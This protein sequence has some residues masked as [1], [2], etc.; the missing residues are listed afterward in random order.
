MKT[1]SLIALSAL[2]FAAGCSSSS[3]PEPQ[4]VDD[5]AALEN[6]ISLGFLG[7][8]TS[9]IPEEKPKGWAL[10][11]VVQIYTDSFPAQRSAV[12]K[13]KKVA[14]NPE[15]AVT[16]E[17]RTGPSDAHGIVCSIGGPNKDTCSLNLLV[18]AST[19][20]DPTGQPVR[21]TFSY[22]P[23][24]FSVRGRIAKLLLEVSEAGQLGPLRCTKTAT[25]AVCEVRP[26]GIGGIVSLYTP[27]SDPS[28]S[29]VE[30]A[31]DPPPSATTR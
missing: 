7:A 21:Q 4:A 23:V 8:C 24:T 2:V 6:C 5:E 18:E 22:K 30:A 25:S 29:S 11:E 17:V 12:A 10:P 27:N 13:M 31:M 3:E 26:E 28:K 15:G 14:T 19:V 9:D 16:A 1:W 20:K